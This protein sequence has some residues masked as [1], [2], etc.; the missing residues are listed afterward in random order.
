MRVRGTA[1][2]EGAYRSLVWYG[3]YSDTRTGRGRWL[4]RVAGWLLVSSKAMGWGVVRGLAHFPTPLAQ[5]WSRASWRVDGLCRNNIH[6]NDDQRQPTAPAHMADRHGMRLFATKSCGACSLCHRRRQRDP[7]A[8]PSESA[9]GTPKGA[10]S[11]DVITST[12]HKP[13]DL[14]VRDEML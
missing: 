11:I 2:E 3:G 14:H 5:S 6:S 9:A 4:S 13:P 7:T 10:R 8:R 12:T 1:C